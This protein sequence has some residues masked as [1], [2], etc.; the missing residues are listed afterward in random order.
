M[1]VQARAF[2]RRWWILTVLCVVPR[3]LEEGQEIRLHKPE[4]EL[5]LGQP[6]TF[7]LYTSTVRARDKASSADRMSSLTASGASLAE[8]TPPA[9]PTSI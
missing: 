1:K 8:F 9:I 4:L 2:E 7:P 5:A 6:V 3:R